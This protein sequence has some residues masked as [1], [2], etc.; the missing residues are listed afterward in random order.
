MN[1]TVF[2]FLIGKHIYWHS[3]AHV[4][5]QALEKKFAAKLCHGPPIESGFYYDVFMKDQYF[6][7]LFRVVVNSD[8]PEIKKLCLQIIKEKQ[9][10][11]RITVSKADL[12]E[13]FQVI[14]I[15]I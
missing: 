5:G 1:L 3:S 4:L 10:F 8:L 9:K 2:I 6:F 13:L 12:F 11:E 15:F 14:L 7:M